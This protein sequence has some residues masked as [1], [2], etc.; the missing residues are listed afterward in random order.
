MKDF[1]ED[2]WLWIVVPFVVVLAVVSYLL[3]FSSSD[4]VSP[5]VYGQ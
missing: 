2:N 1:L 3:F 5:F 4:A